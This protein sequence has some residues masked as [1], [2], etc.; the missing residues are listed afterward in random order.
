[1]T[2]EEDRK[3]FY[4]YCD[5]FQY[6]ATN[7]FAEILSEARKYRLSLTVAHQYM[8]QLSDY[9]RT[10]IFGNVGSIIT[11]RV[12]ADDAAAL[13]KEFT[14]V[15]STRDIINLAV[16]DFYIKMSV[17]GET[18]DAFSGRTIECPTPEKGYR[19][20]IVAH[21]RKTFAK[22]K[23]EVEDLLRKWDESGGDISEE[24]WYSGALDEEFAPPIV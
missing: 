5:E 1:D 21:S 6:F 2:A 23:K 19:D 22:P 15:F 8:G 14:P 20:A 24:A 17:K 11:F 7:T 12:G 10:T 18:R 13:E 3:P 16:R 9:V 4:L